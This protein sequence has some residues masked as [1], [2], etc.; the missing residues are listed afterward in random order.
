[1][2][3]SFLPREISDPLCEELPCNDE[4][5]WPVCDPHGE[6]AILAANRNAVVRRLLAPP[7]EHGVVVLDGND[8]GIVANEIEALQR[9]TKKWFK[10]DS[11]PAFSSSRT[12]LSCFR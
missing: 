7:P 3:K 12:S 1:M 8:R 4:R 10:S 5:L 11:E 6:L 9:K 2:T